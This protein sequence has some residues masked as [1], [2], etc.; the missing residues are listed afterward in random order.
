MQLKPKHTA[1]SPSSVCCWIKHEKTQLKLRGGRKRE[2]AEQREEMSTLT[3]VKVGSQTG[4]TAAV[5][6][7]A[8]RPA[9]IV[10]IR[11]RDERPTCTDYSNELNRIAV[12][13]RGLHRE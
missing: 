3:E 11:C 7:H 5:N 4:P 9:Q 10:W 8:D 6:K 2:A 13:Y 1:D 12:D